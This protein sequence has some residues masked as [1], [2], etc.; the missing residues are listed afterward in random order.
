MKTDINLPLA[1]KATPKR[2]DYEKTVICAKVTTVDVPEISSAETTEVGR[3]DTVFPH[4]LIER[5]GKLYRHV[6]AVGSEA[7]ADCFGRAFTT[8]VRRDDAWTFT[9]EAGNRTDPPPASKALD[10]LV[11]FRAYASIS[12]RV[13]ETTWPY[14]AALR[15]NGENRTRDKFVYEELLGRLAEIDATSFASAIAEQETEAQKLLLVDGDYWIETTPPAIMVSMEGTGRTARAVLQIVH[16]PNWIDRDL[17]KQYFPFDR[18][19]EALE[20]ARQMNN[21]REGHATDALED[22]SGEALA[23]GLDHPLMTFDFEAHAVRR[24]TYVL[25]TDACRWLNRDGVANVKAGPDA[26]RAAYAVRDMAIGCGTDMGEWPDVADVVPDITSA[27][28]ST[29]RKPGWAVLPQNRFWF[30]NLICANAE[31][32]AADLPIYLATAPGWEPAP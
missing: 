9:F 16:L 22:F 4:R 23:H 7:A 1:F 27:W 11:A 19:G 17:S 18:H 10:N 2:N 29:S 20:W 32:M 21:C 26:V 3:F 25:A 8:D 13:D 12:G 28:K 14:Q 15:G 5:D 30:G 6:G 24:A 31:K